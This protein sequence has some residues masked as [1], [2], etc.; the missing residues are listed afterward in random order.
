MKKAAHLPPHDWNARLTKSILDTLP[1]D[2]PSQVLFV[3]VQK[4]FS[5]WNVASQHSWE[6]Y[7]NN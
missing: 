2:P 7:V 6:D 5:S 4:N 1:K 3:F